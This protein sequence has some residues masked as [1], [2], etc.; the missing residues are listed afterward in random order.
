MWEKMNEKLEDRRFAPGLGNK[1][2]LV[3]FQ[4]RIWGI[5]FDWIFI[6]L[7]SMKANEGQY[8]R[9]VWFEEALKTNIELNKSGAR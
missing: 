7:A 4:V 8:L 6:I 3:K 1:K 9:N 5:G 2:V